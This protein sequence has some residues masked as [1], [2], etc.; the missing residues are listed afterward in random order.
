[1]K[2]TSRAKDINPNAKVLST[3]LD[4]WDSPAKGKEAAISQ[5]NDGAD[6]LLQVAD[7]SDSGVIEAAKEKKLFAL[8]S[9]SDQYKLLQTLFLHHLYWMKIRHL[10][11]LLNDSKE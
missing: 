3:Y 8:G 2:A 9:I 10:I 4:E 6:F 11:N 7:T 5:I 1:M